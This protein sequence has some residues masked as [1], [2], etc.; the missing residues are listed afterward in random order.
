LFIAKRILYECVDIYGNKIKICHIAI[1]F[2]LK[3][4]LIICVFTN[5]SKYLVNIERVAK[6]LNGCKRKYQ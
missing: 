2:L 3:L 4:L 5:V 6:I 1:I